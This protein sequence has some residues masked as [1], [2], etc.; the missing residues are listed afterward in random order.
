MR[1]D[2]IPRMSPR[3]LVSLQEEALG[4]SWEDLEEC[5]EAWGRLGRTLYA[6][7]RCASSFWTACL[8]ASFSFSQACLHY[9]L[10]FLHSLDA[11]SLQ[12]LLAYQ[13]CL[14]EPA[15]E[16]LVAGGHDG[17]AVAGAALGAPQTQVLGALRSIPI[18]L[19]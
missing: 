10:H 17:A 5:A 6:T 7:A 14:L 4:L 15:C 1:D 16:V 12:L 2:A 11:H 8:A 9:A 18:G 3:T 19:A 13:P